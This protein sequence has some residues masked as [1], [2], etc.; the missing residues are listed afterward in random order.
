[1]ITIPP[2]LLRA[3]RLL[4]KPFLPELFLVL[5]AA[6]CFLPLAGKLGFYND[7]WYLIYAGTSQGSAKFIEVFEIDRPLR[8]YLVGFLFDWIGTNAPLYSYSAFILRCLGSF[9]L[10]W[11]LRRIWPKARLAAYLA[12]VWFV[13]YP[14]FLDQPNAIDYQSHL[15]GFTLAIFSI[16]F[17]IKALYTSNR[18]GK[19]A[20]V[21][22]AILLQLIYLGLMEYY[23]GL[24]GLR[25]LL[26]GYI[27]FRREGRG[28]IHRVGGAVLQ[29]LPTFLTAAAF[30]I[31]R[32]FIFSGQ[33][34]ATNVESMLADVAGSPALRV[35]WIAALQV[36]D[37]LNTVVFAWFEPVYRV[38]FQLRL[39]YTLE[40]FAWVGAALLFFA[41]AMLSQKE[42]AAPEQTS[43]VGAPREQDMIWLGILGVICALLPT[44]LGNRHVVFQDFGRFSL[45][46]SVGAVMILA[47]LWQLRPKV[48]WRWIL[49]VGLVILASMTHYANARVHAD[50]W[51]TVKEF[52]WQVSW[53]IP[54]LEPQTVLVASYPDQG[55]AEDYFVWGPAN[56][57]YYPQS[58]LSRSTPLT[59]LG[60]TLNLQDIQ[61]IQ[62]SLVKEISRRGFSGVVDYSRTLILTMPGTYSCVHV[63]DG[64]RPELSNLDR[65]EIALISPY[66][67]P[68]LIQTASSSHI[69]PEELFGPEPAHGWCYYYQQAALA[70]Q[71]G[72]WAEVV[73]LGDEAQQL[74]L[75]AS[76]WIEWMPFLEGYAY[77]GIESRVKELSAVI[78]EDLYLRNQA[79]EIILQNSQDAHEHPQ[80]YQLL[81][82]TLCTG[83]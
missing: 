22:L 68:E 76:D 62:A 69:P 27:V 52:W 5:I 19:S 11:L 6:A 25:L 51:E 56:L 54:Q 37:F 23:I 61:A 3:R 20:W 58:T 83:Q 18:W 42:N 79:C 70:R 77:Q 72:D 55:I 66:S 65:A 38:A 81:L 24:E 7:D 8:G 2:I 10:L 13:I 33:R 71:R 48:W 12:A 31:W 34:Q 74:G 60:S 30:L 26:I 15:F 28:W 1:M 49:P 35:L 64:V 32:V 59:L 50:N 57:I 82:E 44:H 41:L 80:G 67:H 47:G 9:G 17:S 53:R 36:Q 75:R 4:Q 21:I 78:R 63:L 39:K 29:A 40:M 46:G 43:Q 14:G 73:R 16:Y 45:P